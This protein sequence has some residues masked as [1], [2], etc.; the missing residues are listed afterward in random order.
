V[1][2]KFNQEH[3]KYSENKEEYLGNFI[4]SFSDML[5]KRGLKA[6]DWRVGSK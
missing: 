4:E 2:N 1:K 6:T 5:L 3:K